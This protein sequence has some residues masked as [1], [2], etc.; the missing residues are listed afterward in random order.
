MR[1]LPLAALSVSMGNCQTL[2]REKGTSHAER[3][4]ARLFEGTY[5]S[6]D[7][8]WRTL[9][10]SSYQLDPHPGRDQLMQPCYFSLGPGAACRPWSHRKSLHL[11]QLF[12]LEDQAATRPES[13]VEMAAKLMPVSFSRRERKSVPSNREALR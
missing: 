7:R 11:M 1:P 6:V 3:Y 5:A 8:A 13:R 9:E 2:R 12:N 4:I 10:P